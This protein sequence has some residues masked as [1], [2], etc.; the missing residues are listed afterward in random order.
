M[1]KKDTKKDEDKNP[2]AVK[3]LEVYNFYC[4]PECSKKT[5]SSEALKSHGIRSHVRARE[6]L[7]PKPVP[8]VQPAK[9]FVNLT[10]GGQVDNSQNV[11][12]VTQNVTPVTESVSKSAI[13]VTRNVR[14]NVTQ[15]T[16]NVTQVSK[17]V[18][19]V[20]TKN[21]AKV[22]QSVTKDTQNVIPVTVKLTMGLKLTVLA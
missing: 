18:T 3:S 1:T 10:L 8:G 21:V 17:N 11:T 14:E 22:S 12:R 9:V 20:T 6:V 4:C 16:P 15:M 7:E 13:R 5:K 2:W 19:Q